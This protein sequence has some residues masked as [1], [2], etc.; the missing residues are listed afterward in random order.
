MHAE[1]ELIDGIDRS[2]A[3]GA[4]IAAFF[5]TPILRYVD[6]LLLV[7]AGAWA[8]LGFGAT[9]TVRHL[10]GGWRYVGTGT[11][12]LCLALAAWWIVPAGIQLQTSAAANDRRCLAIQRDMLSAQPRRADGPDLFQSLGCRPQGGG[13]VFAEPTRLEGAAG[14]A[15]PGG[16]RR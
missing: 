3:A 2:L 10:P 5:A 15:L 11:S 14:H 4:I 9:F 6:P 1:P 7:E 8:A 12:V 16:G 13:S